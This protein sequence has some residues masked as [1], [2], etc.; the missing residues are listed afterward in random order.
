MGGCRALLPGA[1]A[2]DAGEL[3][4]AGG[5]GRAWGLG[6]D[7]GAAAVIPVGLGGCG[8]RKYDSGWW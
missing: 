8:A 6:P 1:V 3:L 5:G 7:A 2:G 4:G